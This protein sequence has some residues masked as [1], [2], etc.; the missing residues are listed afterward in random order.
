M[1]CNVPR[2]LFALLVGIDS[3]P[4]PVSSLTGAVNDVR[5]FES[6]LNAR[7]SPDFKIDQRVLLNE[8]ATRAALIE[9]FEHHLSRAGPGDV[10]LFVFSGHGSQQLSPEEFWDIEP[11]HRNETLVCW[12][13]RLEGSWDLADKEIAGLITRVSRSG[14]HTVVI[15][16]C[17]HSGSGT[18][19]SGTRQIRMDQRE[20]SL[21]T[22]WGGPELAMNLARDLPRSGREIPRASGWRFPK[23]EH[24]LLAA[25]ASNEVAREIPFDGIQRGVFSYYLLELLANTNAPLTYRTLFRAAA[26]RVLVQ[27][28]SQTPQIEPTN[29]ALLDL[30]FLTGAATG[31]SR[32]FL[33]HYDP[34][35]GWLVDAGAIHGIRPP[36]RRLSLCSRTI[37]QC[38]NRRRRCERSVPRCERRD[39]QRSGKPCIA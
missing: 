2:Q 20:R 8:H 25:C 16:D 6:Y 18:R 12:D 31:G 30:E 1:E 22:F 23:G 24:I 27:A 26:A 39:D 28:G 4:Q 33:V 37:R 5:A 21:A 36:A 7:I 14:A 34:K 32:W 38:S 3:Y 9:A 13:S 29:P 19:A 35:R 11:D 10:A 17:C 15:L